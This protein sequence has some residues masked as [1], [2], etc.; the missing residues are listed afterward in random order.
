MKIWSSVFVFLFLIIAGSSFATDYYVAPGGSDSHSGTSPEQAF[1]TFTPALLAAEPGD[2]IYAMGG[3][4]DN[5]NAVD[6]V[7]DNGT[8]RTFLNISDRI[9]VRDGLESAPIT[10]TNYPG[11]T[12][13]LDASIFG[14]SAAAVYI[15]QK[16]YWI[17]EGFEIVG[18]MIL[19]QQSDGSRS[20][21]ITLQNN[22]IRD[23]DA[24][25]D[26]GVNQGII[27]INRSDPGFRGPYNFYIRNNII[28]NQHR[29]SSNWEESQIGCLG[30]LA[31]VSECGYD[32]DI[33]ACTGKVEFSGNIVYEVPRVFFFKTVAAG[34]MEIHDNIFHDSQIVGQFC[35]ANAHIIN[36]LFYRIPVGP[37]FDANANWDGVDGDVQ[38]L[39]GSDAVIQ[40]NTFVGLDRFVGIYRNG[41]HRIE[42]N[43]FVGLPGTATDGDG[44][45]IA[46]SEY[47]PDPHPPDY[48]GSVLRTM[49][50]NNNCFITPE[51]NFLSVK[52]IWLD[53]PVEHLNPVQAMDEATFGFDIDS[54]F[55]VDTDPA[56]IF[57][58]P[59]NNDYTVLDGHPCVDLGYGGIM[60]PPDSDG[61]NAS[62]GCNISHSE[63]TSGL[64][65]L[66]LLATL[67]GS[68][69]LVRRVRGQHL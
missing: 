48:A 23:L 8:S 58:D 55:I 27:T 34:P 21:D 6:Y 64:S 63:N 16:Q 44:S 12:P 28:H 68:M 19:I 31:V 29:G 49:T 14:T 53:Y 5:D 52:R 41:G 30:V 67:L 65:L 9:G 13:V 24:G 46:K 10:V 37:Y 40:N 2:T 26:L 32:Q 35:A 1:K 4:Y 7:H 57:V 25:T 15:Y 60:P 18:G 43:I 69:I 54:T 20:H 11:E 22:E 62:G 45:Y 61:E 47:F 50:S 51:A 36:N 59:A 3:T 56:N 33:N 42:R 66:F 39:E 38:N 17:V